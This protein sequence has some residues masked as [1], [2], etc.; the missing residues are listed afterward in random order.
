M[1]AILETSELNTIN[2]ISFLGITIGLLFIYSDSLG[3]IPNISASKIAA[4]KKIGLILIILCV[5]I[6]IYFK[7][8][9]KN[10]VETK[11]S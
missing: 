1:S 6:L 3:I 2:L 5:L 7:F 9:F 8:F 10:E 11:W 4:N